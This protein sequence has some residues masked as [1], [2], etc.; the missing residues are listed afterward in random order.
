MYQLN[1]KYLRKKCL[2][3]KFCSHKDRV[4]NNDQIIEYYYIL[5]NPD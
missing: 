1:K 4:Y 2:L 3:N 5:L